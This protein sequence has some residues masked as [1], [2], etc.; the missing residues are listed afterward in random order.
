MG[1]TVNLGIVSGIEVTYSDRFTINPLPLVNALTRTPPTVKHTDIWTDL[2]FTLFYKGSC[3]LRYEWDSKCQIIE[4]LLVYP[5]DRIAGVTDSSGKVL[6]Y[7]DGRTQVQ[8][9]PEYIISFR[10]TKQEEHD[11]RAICIYLVGIGNPKYSEVVEASKK[12]YEA[13]VQITNKKELSIEDQIKMQVEKLNPKSGDLLILKDKDCTMTDEGFLTVQKWVKDT[14][15]CEFLIVTGDKLFECVT[16]ETM[17]ELGW[18][19]KRDTRR[20]FF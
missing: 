18:V 8:Y 12:G 1:F 3:F 10:R 15:N 19:K 6:Y 20:E 5:P 4:K 7:T 16:E 2:I 13:A 11:Y 17:N 9:S 14:Y